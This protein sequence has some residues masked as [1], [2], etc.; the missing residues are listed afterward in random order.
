MMLRAHGSSFKRSNSTYGVVR[1]LWA[2]SVTS[3]F[4]EIALGKLSTVFSGA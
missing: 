2:K 3:A 4:V 1:Q